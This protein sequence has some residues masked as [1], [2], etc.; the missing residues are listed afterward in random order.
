MDVKVN[1]SVFE[2]LIKKFV[3]EHSNSRT[4]H[5]V[6]I[7]QI[8]GDELPVLP[9][10][11]MPLQL[12]SEMPNVADEEYMPTTT[13]ALSDAAATIAQA[14]PDNQVEFFYNQLHN[15][16]KR[17][18]D[19]EEESRIPVMEAL[20]FEVLDEMLNEDE[21]DDIQAK[22]D[23]QKENTQSMT[24][25]TDEP[26]ELPEMSDDEMDAMISN[27]ADNIQSNLTSESI[28]QMIVQKGHNRRD[29]IHSSKDTMNLDLGHVKSSSAN[30]VD[31]GHKSRRVTLPSEFSNEIVEH[32]IKNDSEIAKMFFDYVKEQGTT[33]AM[34]VIDVE[35]SLKDI[36]KK[37]EDI[38]T[39]LVAEMFANITYDRLKKSVDNDNSKE[40]IESVID[41]AI[42]VINDGPDELPA[43]LTGMDV[44]M[45]TKSDMIKFLRQAVSKNSPDIMNQAVAD[46]EFGTEPDNIDVEEDVFNTDK[47]ERRLD[48]NLENQSDLFG[49]SGASGI[50]QWFQKHPEQKFVTLVKGASD[51]G[52]EK[53]NKQ[54]FSALEA[55]IMSPGVEKWIEKIRSTTPEGLRPEAVEKVIDGIESIIK[56]VTTGNEEIDFDKLRTTSAG[57]I[58]RGAFD[59]LLLG[60]TFTT[61]YNHRENFSKQLISHLDINEK[62]RLSI[63]NM[64]AG[65]STAPNWDKTGIPLN[66]NAEKVI[67][68]GI[69]IE[70]FKNM[71]KEVAVEIEGYFDNHLGDIKNYYNKRLQS[72]KG[73]NDAL[74][75]AVIDTRDHFE[76]LM[77]SKNVRKTLQADGKE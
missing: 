10:E 72:V 61:F 4:T 71:L 44:V 33:Q 58:I 21:W 63:I 69:T 16:L 77:A 17:V 19:R 20:M 43:K 23:A 47:A 8:A 66:R 38:S 25:N 22:I 64:L 76:E 56:D 11:H 36:M 40:S 46:E 28:A 57:F 75:S 9:N 34:A 65:I 59:K 31:F 50:R 3:N 60:K 26:E 2:Q 5:S 35:K 48:K 54:T 53:M 6:R 1:K 45:I 68:A 12:S 24:N 52:G 67:E 62:L 32:A 74:D 27:I 49:F 55:L 70:M 30:Y 13:S 29:A 37:E 73:I 51:M 41:S 39:E 7:D 15:L 18:M 42:E 14:V